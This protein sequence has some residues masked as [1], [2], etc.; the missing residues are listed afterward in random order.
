MSFWNCMRKCI[1]LISMDYYQG[2]CTVI[3]E[4]FASGKP[5]ILVNQGGYSELVTEGVNG[6]LVGDEVSEVVKG[7]TRMTPEVAAKMKDACLEKAKEFTMSTFYGKWDE[8]LGRAKTD[9]R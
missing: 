1:S 4:A 6:T 7:V 5:C 8:I 3:I 2:Y 9:S